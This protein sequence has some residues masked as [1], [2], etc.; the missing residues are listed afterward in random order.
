MHRLARKK[1]DC[2]INCKKKLI[3]LPILRQR[4]RYSHLCFGE[5]RGLPVSGFLLERQISLNI[6]MYNNC[7]KKLSEVMGNLDVWSDDWLHRKLHEPVQRNL[8]AYTRLLDQAS[9]RRR[10]ELS[11][12][13]TN[14]VT[15]T[16][17]GSAA[18]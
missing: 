9:L 14:I 18:A 1:T 3:K 13:G 2:S 7:K 17:V 15:T 11:N 4:R 5:L 6:L 8:W 12:T 16:V 10:V